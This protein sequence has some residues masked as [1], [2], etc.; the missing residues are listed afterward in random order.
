MLFWAQPHDFQGS[1]SGW[2]PTLW[3]DVAQKGHGTCCSS[4]ALPAMRGTRHGV[5]PLSWQRDGGKRGTGMGSAGA[6]ASPATLRAPTCDTPTVTPILGGK[7]GASLDPPKQLKA[8][9]WQR[10]PTDP[11]APPALL[12]LSLAGTQVW[13]DVTPC[14]WGSQASGGGDTP[15]TGTRAPTWLWLCP[16]HPPVLPHIAAPQ[17]CAWQSRLLTGFMAH[18]SP[19][20][21]LPPGSSAWH[22]P[23]GAQGSLA[24]GG[25]HPHGGRKEV[26]HLPK[27]SPNSTPLPA[28][29]RS[30]GAPGP[31]A[32]ALSISPP[33][34]E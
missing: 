9:R 20:H 11:L 19:Q 6:N 31:A 1:R 17:R 16:G 30:R 21:L 25:G 26:L 14:G 23:R 13:G 8:G 15:R 33:H 2:I 27:S 4:L 7:L 24:G 5:A 10:C 29:T 28:S 34:P 18:S 32:P 22:G 12:R 3:P